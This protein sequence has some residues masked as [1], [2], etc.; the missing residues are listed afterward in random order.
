M[1]AMLAQNGASAYKQVNRFS[2]IEGASPHQ[3]IE[4]LLKGAL[5]K[6]AIAKGYMAREDWAEKGVE[7]NKS[8]AI[9]QELRASIDIESGGTLAQRLDNLYDYM[10]RTLLTANLE[11]ST[12]KL[13]EVTSLLGEIYESW[14]L[15]PGD[16]RG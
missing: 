10:I 3:L 14:V 4:M 7:L 1:N 12:A 13:D 11:N 6:I 8:I 15:I 5:D 9:V 16:L 2:G